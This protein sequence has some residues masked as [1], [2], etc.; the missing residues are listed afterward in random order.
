[1]SDRNQTTCTNPATGEVIGSSPL[2]D[3]DDLRAALESSRRAQTS[4]ARTPVGERA[5]ALFRL[6]DL[7]LRLG[8]GFGA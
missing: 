7:G 2:H 8:L 5:K 3:L 1:M 4:W 6:R